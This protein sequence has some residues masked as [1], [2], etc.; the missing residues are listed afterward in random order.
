MVAK[1][2]DYPTVTLAG[3]VAADLG[4]HLPDFRA[5]E[6][7]FCV[8]RASLRPQ[9]PD[10]PRRSDRA[11]VRARASGDRL[12]GAARLRWL[13]SGGT[14]GPCG[15]RLSAGPA[16]GLLGSHRARSRKRSRQR[17]RRYAE[18]LRDADVAEVLG[19][20]PYPIARVNNEWRY[21]IALRSRKPT[22]LRKVVR[23]RI[24][25]AARADRST[26]LAINVDP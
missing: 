15:D 5:A 6:R 17:P 3:V 16:P 4:L 25:K 26:R 20:A 2:L 9:R 21:R 19:P 23:D 1:G 8:D 7:S 12:R 11:N 24:L 13:R 18:L 14:P 10:A 22:A